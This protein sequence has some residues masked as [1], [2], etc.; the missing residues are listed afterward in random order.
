MS[1]GC[2]PVCGFVFTRSEQKGLPWW[3]DTRQYAMF[4][5][6]GA[7]LLIW[8]FSTCC[9]S[10]CP[11]LSEQVRD[12][13]PYSTVAAG[14]R[15]TFWLPG[16]ECA[17]DLFQLISLHVVSQD[18]A[19]HVALLAREIWKM[20][21]VTATDV[22]LPT[23]GWGIIRARFWTSFNRSLNIQVLDGNTLLWKKPL[24]NDTTALRV[25]IPA[26]GDMCLF[27]LPIL[28]MWNSQKANN[29]KTQPQFL[30]TNLSQLCRP[31][32]F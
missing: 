13:V 25:K 26:S 20:E 18:G 29:K 16:C 11:R 17:F 27:I 28:I 23:R 1:A 2:C 32:F 19:W 21:S 3:R 14:K 24:K 22:S 10:F 4:Q 7:V 15:A 9:W 12:N 8:L 6:R 31:A 5:H 30:S